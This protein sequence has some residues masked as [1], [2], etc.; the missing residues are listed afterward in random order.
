LGAS[1]VFL[2]FSWIRL[3]IYSGVYK[4]RLGC[5]LAG[6]FPSSSNHNATQSK[7]DLT[8]H[9]SSIPHTRQTHRLTS[10]SSS[11]L[12]H[13]MSSST[14]SAST[15]GNA[16]PVALAHPVTPAGVSSAA[17]L[18]RSLGLGKSSMEKGKEKSCGCAVCG[19]L[20]R[21]K[22]VSHLRVTGDADLLAL[23]LSR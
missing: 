15:S 12:R 1:L 16:T 9:R 17:A 2:D 8:Q 4:K 14:S 20:S 18:G 19:K 21:W 13:D 3:Y 23:T 11:S 10:L 6:P 22:E 7:A 5:S